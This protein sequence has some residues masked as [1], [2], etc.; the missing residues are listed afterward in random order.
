MPKGEQTL[1]TRQRVAAANGARRRKPVP[2][3]SNCGGKVKPRPALIGRGSDAVCVQCG[4]VRNW[5]RWSPFVDGNGVHIKDRARELRAAG[6]SYRAVGELLG[7]IDNKSVA[8]WC[9]GMDSAAT[10]GTCPR[11]G[12]ATAAR[13]QDGEAVCVQ[14]G[15]RESLLPYKRRSHHIGADG[16]YLPDT[17]RYMA[18]SLGMTIASISET[19]N[20]PMGT[21]GNWIKQV[22][23]DLLYPRGSNW[24]K[25]D[26][27]RVIALSE[28][29]LTFAAIE[30]QTGV[31]ATTAAKWIK[32][33]REETYG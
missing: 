17:A 16:E 10:N 21:V 2:G 28:R 12:G 11:C 29:G 8:S 14:C 22:E 31:P 7:G 33:H 18:R 23:R 27:R 32:R 5:Y 26:H 3:C 1:V 19:L 15:R 24:K 4:F 20:V 13:S 30:R 6:H 25:S 9:V